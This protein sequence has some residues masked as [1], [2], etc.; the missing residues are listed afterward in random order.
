VYARVQRRMGKVNASTNSSPGVSSMS[1]WGLFIR[2]IKRHCYNVHNA[3][4]QPLLYNS[5]QLRGHYGF[6]RFINVSVPNQ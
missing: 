2:E 3:P 1:T 4:I 5:A 6:L